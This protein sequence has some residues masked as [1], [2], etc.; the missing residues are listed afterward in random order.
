MRKE[1][2]MA[3][4]MMQRSLQIMKTWLQTVPFTRTH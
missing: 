2:G 3:V 1:K 4:A